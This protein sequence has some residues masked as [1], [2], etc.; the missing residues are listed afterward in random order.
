[1]GQGPRSS[2]S[3]DVSRRK[4]PRPFPEFPCLFSL[5]TSLPLSSLS[6]PFF[7]SPRSFQTAIKSLLTLDLSPLA[8]FLS[9]VPSRNKSLFTKI[10][11]FTRA[12]ASAKIHGTLSEPCCPLFS[13]APPSTPT[14][15]TL[16]YELQRPFGSSLYAL[17]ATSHLIS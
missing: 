4:S 5:L 3:P 15:I 2:F 7:C 13:P 10:A 16:S 9:T 11:S 8:N 12:L 14:I 17:S 6:P 1:M